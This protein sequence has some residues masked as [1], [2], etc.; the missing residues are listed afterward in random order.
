MLISLALAAATLNA[1]AAAFAQSGANAMNQGARVTVNGVD[2]YYETHGEGAPLVMLHGGVNP[3]EMFGV[4]LTEMAENHKVIAVQLRGHGYSADTSEPWSYELMADDVAALMGEIGVE[5]ADVMGYSLGAGVALQL[6]IRHPERVKKL[7]AISM[8][9]RFDGDYP[10]IRAAFDSMTAAAPAIA[11]NIE[12]SPLA[13]L[14]PDID[15]TTMMRKTGE[16]N[17]MEHDWRETVAEIKSPVLVMFGDADSIQLEHM[18]AFYR[19][20]GGGQRDGGIDGSGR[21]ANQFAVIPNRTHY[22]I[23]ASPAVTTFAKDFLAGR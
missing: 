18:T 2:L 3:S 16:M 6:T 5:S 21:S 15:W 10:E 17:Q 8:A 19:L 9:Y 7:V 11:E 4:P 1:T 23:L 22:N 12:A 14:Y 20:L 13:T